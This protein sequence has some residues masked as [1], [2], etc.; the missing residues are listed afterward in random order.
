M[1]YAHA[2]GGWGWCPARARA[3]AIRAGTWA[4]TRA[5]G[6]RVRWSDVALPGPALQCTARPRFL[7]YYGP[8]KSFPLGSWRTPEAQTLLSAQK[9]WDPLDRLLAAGGLQVHSSVR[10]AP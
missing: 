6:P 9:T 4:G 1:T 8:R 2:T 3:R 5:G 10:G 7:R